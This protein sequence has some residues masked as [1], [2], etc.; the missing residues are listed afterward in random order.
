MDFTQLYY[1]K[2]I[3]KHEH[4]TK[5]SKE[6]LIT[7]PALSRNLSKLESEL[8]VQLFLREGRRLKL[9]NYGKLLLKH[10]DLILKELAEIP[11]SLQREQRK[12]KEILYLGSSNTALSTPWLV[13]FHQ[14][15][16]YITLRHKTLEENVIYNELLTNHINFAI[17]IS[18]PK[19]SYF[20]SLKLF[21]DTYSILVRKNHPL[22]HTK[23]LYF[24]ETTDLDFIALPQSE[25]STRF[26]DFLSKASSKSPNIVFEGE[27]EFLTRYL[28]ESD[29]ATI[30]L[31][32]GFKEIDTFFPNHFHAINLKDSFAHFDVFCAW[33][34]TREEEMTYKLFIDFLHELK[35]E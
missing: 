12:T 17:T 35:S 10:T 27:S 23:S 30:I 21:S 20:K 1:F 33:K 11:L 5:A 22:S 31:K 7:Q 24:N 18:P 19:E 34:T 28:L 8:G 25:S 2:T 29:T 6:L 26:I 3:A 16:P 13:K 15:N 14:A 4:L 9:N 32:S